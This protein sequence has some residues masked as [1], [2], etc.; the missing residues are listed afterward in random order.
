MIGGTVADTGPGAYAGCVGL[1]VDRSIA[2]DAA[3]G[4]RGSGLRRVDPLCPDIE[5]IT[6]A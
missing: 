4:G 2:V 5:G 3:P 6:E 1:A